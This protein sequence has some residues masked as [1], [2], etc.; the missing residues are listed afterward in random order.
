MRHFIRIDWELYICFGLDYMFK[1]VQFL[2]GVFI[3]LHLNNSFSRCK[4]SF[5]TRPSN[6]IWHWIGIGWEMRRCWNEPNL[7]KK[8]KGIPLGPI[9]KHR[10]IFG[11]R[12]MHFKDIVIKYGFI[13]FQSIFVLF[14]SIF[15]IRKTW[16]LIVSLKV[17][18]ST[19]W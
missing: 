8:T 2:Y 11:E 9:V 4:T 1:W 18:K 12:K 3:M 15:T 16:V 14:C 13:T 5:W 17:K 10:Y 19:L 6:Q 7:G